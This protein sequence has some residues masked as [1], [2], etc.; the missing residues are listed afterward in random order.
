MEITESCNQKI[1]TT[2]IL[3]QILQTQ[4]EDIDLT[5]QA[6]QVQLLHLTLAKLVIS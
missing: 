3:F 6:A 2:F 4:G 1:S 5:L